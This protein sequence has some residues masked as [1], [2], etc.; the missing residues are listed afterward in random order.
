MTFFEE[1]LEKYY[2]EEINGVRRN[3]RMEGISVKYKKAIAM[4]FFYVDSETTFVFG[5][6]FYRKIRKFFERRELEEKLKEADIGIN[7]NN[8]GSVPYEIVEWYSD[9]CLKCRNCMLQFGQI[10]SILRVKIIENYEF[11]V[12]LRKFK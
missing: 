8:D 9:D 3:R 11:H 10:N 7:M 4:V 1:I 2:F 6:R 5:A 12:V